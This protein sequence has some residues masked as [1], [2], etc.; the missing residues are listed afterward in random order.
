MRDTLN[1]EYFDWLYDLVCGT[2]FSEHISYKKLF[3]YLHNTDFRYSIL[4]DGSRAED[5]LDLRYRFARDMEYDPE[6]V[7][8]C[9]DQPCSVLEMII[10]LAVRCEETLMDDPEKGDR[11]GQ[12]FWGMIA[13]LGL[14]SMYDLYFDRQIVE[15][16]INRFLDREY[17]PDGR[18]GLFTIRNCDCD[19]RDVEIWHQF[20]W[21]LDSFA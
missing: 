16:I 6:L 19:L 21:Y 14:R 1:N 10:A 20:C 9:I 5:G 2:R 15:D 7:E 13:N 18:G 8:E 11:T 17:D 12:W 4:K 3:M